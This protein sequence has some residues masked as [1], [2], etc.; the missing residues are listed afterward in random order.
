MRIL[1]R[2]ESPVQQIRRIRN[3]FEP[4]DPK[5]RSD[6]HRT[7]TLSERIRLCSNRFH[8]DDDITRLK[9]L[10]LKGSAIQARAKTTHRAFRPP[11]RNTTQPAQ[12]G[13][14][15]IA[16][17]PARLATTLRSTWRASS[18]SFPENVELDDPFKIRIQD[19]TG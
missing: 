4:H 14:K 3:L 9:F 19:N 7:I 10:R 11:K 17:G 16:T 18:W 6:I 5:T 1:N 2:T 15:R 13:S 12:Q 8:L